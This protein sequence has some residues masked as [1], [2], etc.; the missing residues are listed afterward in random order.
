MIH[1]TCFLNTFLF[2]MPTSVLKKLSN[3]TRSLLSEMQPA[4]D[5]TPPSPVWGTE[6]QG[7]TCFN[8][9]M[10]R[11]GQDVFWSTTPNSAEG[12]ELLDSLCKCV[13]AA[14]HNPRQ[15]RI[16]PHWLGSSGW[17]GRA[18][19]AG[20]CNQHLSPLGWQ[21]LRATATPAPSDKEPKE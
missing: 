16:H 4:A 18:R 13:T 3:P 10:G 12:A 5:F 7:S 15:S 21:A 2:L 14:E 9:A 6:K 11:R 20:V 17:R 1:I 19:R 8:Q